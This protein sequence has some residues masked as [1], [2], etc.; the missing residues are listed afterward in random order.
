MALLAARLLR[1]ASA[2]VRRRLHQ[3]AL[4]ALSYE[5]WLARTFITWR[6]SRRLNQQLGDQSHGVF[7]YETLDCL[8]LFEAV[9]PS[10]RAQQLLAVAKDVSPP[11]AP[12]FPKL[13]QQWPGESWA[14]TID[15]IE[16]DLRRRELW[17]PN[18]FRGMIDSVARIEHP[19]VFI[20]RALDAKLYAK[21]LDRLLRGLSEGQSSGAVMTDFAYVQNRARLEAIGRNGHALV[22]LNPHGVCFVTSPDGALPYA[23][24]IALRQTWQLKWTEGL[25]QEVVDNAF[26]AQTAGFIRDPSRFLAHNNTHG[27]E[28]LSKRKVIA[29]HVIRDAGS[30]AAQRFDGIPIRDYFEWAELMLTFVDG[31]WNEWAVKTH[32]ARG[33]YPDED[34]IVARLLARF[35]VPSSAMLVDYPME[36]LIQERVPIFTFAGTIAYEC[37][38]RGVLAYTFSQTSLSDVSV[39]VA[40]MERLT[41]YS[42]LLE[43]PSA[44]DAQVS[45][46]RRVLVGDEYSPINGLVPQR[47]TSPTLNYGLR[48]RSE[49]AAAWQMW[50]APR[51][52]HRLARHNLAKLF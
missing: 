1:R 10:I 24:E 8:L 40:S 6:L 29:L 7:N 33:W 50:R 44:T 28:S 2:E 11:I 18:I 4:R 9:A 43:A 5:L 26:F 27:I 14:K 39:H 42:E 17:T 21:L 37:A 25:S 23:D 48:L 20:G 3:V 41:A 52:E 38:A 22:C 19:D 16:E 47:A 49:Y 51:T 46:A 30:P 13:P 31:R 35:D 15:E 36:S 32:P 34:E 45:V 12:L